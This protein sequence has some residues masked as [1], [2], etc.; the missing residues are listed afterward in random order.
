MIYR[1]SSIREPKVYEAVRK[2]VVPGARVMAMGAALNM[3]SNVKDRGS[4]KTVAKLMEDDRAGVKA[5]AAAW[6]YRMGDVTWA[7]ELTAALRTG[8]VGSSEFSRVY[9]LLYS[10][11]ALPEDVLAAMAELLAVED[12]NSSVLMNAIRL[13]SKSRYRKATGAIRK[14]LD[15]RISSVSKAAFDALLALEGGLDAEAVRPLLESDDVEKRLMGADAL[16]RLNDHSGLPIV[17]TIL[18][19]GE[20]NDRAEAARVLGGFRVP[21]AVEPLLT[22]LSDRNSTVRMRASY[23]LTPVLGS[24]FPYRRFNL[25][26]TGYSYGA[27]PEANRAAIAVI[28][29]FWEE[30][31]DADW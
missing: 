23:A 5:M 21:A 29:A 20:A 12:Q 11:P 16:R 19:K 26:A 9:S 7:K 1:L 15:H 22:A 14:L 4:I 2:F 24:L 6:L 28:R 10:V 18:E 31:K 27:T 8:E 30:H 25:A 17:L 13:L 3:L